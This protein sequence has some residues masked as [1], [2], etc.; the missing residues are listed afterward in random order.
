MHNEAD[1]FS[2][3]LIDVTGLSLRDLDRLPESSLAVALRQV[4]TSD[5]VGPS[6]GFS[7]RVL[8]S[9]PG[10]PAAARPPRR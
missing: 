6:A 8:G 10:V 7:A 2:G 9:G 3:D 5:G 1:D 4:L